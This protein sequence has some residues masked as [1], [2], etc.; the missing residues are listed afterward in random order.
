MEWTPHY[1][2]WVVD[3][4]EVRHVSLAHSVHPADR[5]AI[6]HLNKPQ[7]LRM[8][9]WTPTFHAWG[10]GLDPIDMPW[11]VLYDYVEVFNY[12]VEHNEFKFHWRDDF[13]AFDS[14]RW[15]KASG[16]F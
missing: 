7:S 9:F 4:H 14:S 8:N 11:Y 10:V 2:S 16:E 6:E 13:S 3:G 12:D 1:V 5:A 15:A